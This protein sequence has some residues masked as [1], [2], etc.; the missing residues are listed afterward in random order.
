MS[1]VVRLTESSQQ[2]LLRV[3]LC[4]R[5]TLTSCMHC[6]IS[7][8]GHPD[9]W[10]GGI[11]PVRGRPGAGVLRLSQSSYP[12]RWV[13]GGAG[14]LRRRAGP[15][16]RELH[17]T[18]IS[19]VSPGLR[20]ALGLNPTPSYGRAS[21][22]SATSGGCQ[23]SHRGRRRALCTEPTVRHAGPG[24]SVAFKNGNKMR[25]WGVPLPAANLQSI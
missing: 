4:A 9:V 3:W 22:F 5:T 21:A 1:H 25:M 6:L 12:H 18:P 8:P 14:G 15:R 2:H 16:R 19:Q 10:P 20:A 23:A 17:I 7:S 13:S 24:P 11:Q